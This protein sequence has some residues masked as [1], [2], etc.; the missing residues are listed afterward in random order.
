MCPAEGALALSLAKG[1]SSA[2]PRFSMFGWKGALAPWV[3]AACIAAI[4]FG[5][6][7]YARLSGHWQS[8]VPNAIYLRLVPNADLE[9]HPGM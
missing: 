7:G 6:V 1:A 5:L 3:V 4:F 9:T 8:R 2:R